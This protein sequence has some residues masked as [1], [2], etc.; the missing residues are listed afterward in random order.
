MSE[1]ISAPGSSYFLHGFRTW[2]SYSSFQMFEPEMSCSLQLDGYTKPF[3]P[4]GVI[5]S[6][7]VGGLITGFDQDVASILLDGQKMFG[8]HSIST[9]FNSYCEEEMSTLINKTHKHRHNELWVIADAIH[10]I[11]AYCIANTKDIVGVKA[12]RRECQERKIELRS[13]P[14]T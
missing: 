1:F 12:F 2:N 5:I 8:H 6:I 7:E 3:R 13:V 11:G 9:N 10:I 14:T 4:F